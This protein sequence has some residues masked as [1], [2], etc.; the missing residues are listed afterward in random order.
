LGNCG[1]ILYRIFSG[2]HVWQLRRLREGRKAPFDFGKE[3]STVLSSYRQLPFSHPEEI[4]ENSGSISWGSN[5][6][7][8]PARLNH[9]NKEFSYLH[10]AACVGQH[11][12][13]SRKISEDPTLAKGNGEM[14]ILLPAS[15]GLDSELVRFLLQA[16]VDPQDQVKLTDKSNLDRGTATVWMLFLFCFAVSALENRDWPRFDF[17][18]AV[19]EEYLKFGVDREVFFLVYLRSDVSSDYRETATSQ[20][21]RIVRKEGR[22]LPEHE[23]FSISLEELIHLKQPKNLDALQALLLDGAKRPFWSKTSSMISKFLPWIESSTPITSEYKAFRFTELEDS[24]FKL[25]SVCSKTC[26]LKEGFAFRI[27]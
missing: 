17:R 2:S 18:S 3:L 20:S 4:G 13:V 15:Y 26:Q 6:S 14:S 24:K 16:G 11:Q 27:W 1:N 21:K 12:Y 9:I 7:Y 10:Y 22:K 5:L 25:H 19:L 23:L 8:L